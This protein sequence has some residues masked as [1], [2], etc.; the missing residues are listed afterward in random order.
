MLP[1]THAPK[2]MSS[3]RALQTARRADSRQIS[4]NM[5]SSSMNP[6]YRQAAIPFYRQAAIMRAARLSLAGLAL[7]VSTA[8]SAQF[9]PHDIV[10]H[11]RLQDLMRSCQQQA[12]EQFGVAREEETDSAELR[13]AAF[14]CL[15]D[16]GASHPR[17]HGAEPG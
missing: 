3:A 2:L 8:A 15:R 14:Q 11:A 17:P 13:D 6:L 7:A 1:I 9:S 5:R 12:R 16:N 4:S 10:T